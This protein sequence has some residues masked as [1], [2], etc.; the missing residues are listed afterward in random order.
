MTTAATPPGLRFSLREFLLLVAAVV[1][2]LCALI[3]GNGMWLAAVAAFTMLAIMT[4]L[5]V[6]LADRGHRQ[7]FALGFVACAVTYLSI[8]F[9]ETEIH[10][11]QG[12]FP[13]TRLLRIFF[14]SVRERLYVDESSGDRVLHSDIPPAARIIEDN[15]WTIIS[16]PSQGGSVI[17]EMNSRPRGM[18]GSAGVVFRRIGDF[19]DRRQFMPTGHLLWAL[20]FGYIGGHFGRRV[21]RRRVLEQAVVPTGL[22]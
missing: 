15:S 9:V 8:F 7:A 10:P 21:Y 12:R 5:I 1:V 22:T 16:P 4:Q 18:S 11:Y 17:A 20:L 3:F 14:E 2:G 13:T 19:P 6:A